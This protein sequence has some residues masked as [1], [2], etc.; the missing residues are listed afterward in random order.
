MKIGYWAM[1]DLLSITQ[2]PKKCQKKP[3]NLT[4]HQNDEKL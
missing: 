1:K 4:I 3:K 2:M